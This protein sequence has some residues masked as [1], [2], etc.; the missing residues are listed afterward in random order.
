MKTLVMLAS[1]LTAAALYA[2]GPTAAS[3]V[4]EGLVAQW[5]ALENAGPGAYAADATT[6]KDLAGTHDLAVD[7]T[8]AVWNGGALHADGTTGFAVADE[9]IA[10]YKTVEICYRTADGTDP[11]GIFAC[12]SAE[13]FG[14][15]V[16]NVVVKPGARV[17]VAATYGDLPST[18]P[19]AV[20]LDGVANEHVVCESWGEQPS[21][22]SVGWGLPPD[23]AFCGDV[24]AIRLSSRALT[25][26]EIAAH[27]AGDQARCAR[28]PQ[29]RRRQ[30]GGHEPSERRE[31]D[32]VRRGGSTHAVLGRLARLP[33]LGRRRGGRDA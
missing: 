21:V 18:S 29:D 24:C 30:C 3:Y 6:W 5:D 33:H 32:I 20:Y 16:T 1:A 7:L 8:K 11:H 2:E 26:A 23:R 22:F 13:R 19:A 31:G 15:S 14:W 28:H 9:A 10:D 25:A 17:C 12:G 4:Q 27:A